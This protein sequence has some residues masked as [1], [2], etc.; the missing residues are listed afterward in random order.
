MI[1][2]FRI[3]SKIT[4]E[5]Q[6][7][8]KNK[9]DVHVHV[10]RDGAVPA[11]QTALSLCITTLRRCIKN[12]NERVSAVVVSMRRPSCRKMSIADLPMAPKVSTVQLTA[13][14]FNQL[15]CYASSPELSTAVKFLYFFSNC[16]EYLPSIDGWQAELVSLLLL[17]IVISI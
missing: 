2:Q 4:K 7:M 6:N 3:Y 8:K 17:F 1:I 14:N 10:A 15:D 5:K 13:S 16:T 12:A 11:M 9:L